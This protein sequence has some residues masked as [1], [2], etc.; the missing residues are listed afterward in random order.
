MLI[1]N[2]FLGILFISHAGRYWWSPLK[3]VAITVV[4]RL[5]LLPSIYHPFDKIIIIIRN[6][7]SAIMPL[8]GYRGFVKDFK[9]LNMFLVAVYHFFIT[10]CDV[11]VCCRAVLLYICAY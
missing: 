10:D 11:F 3:G 6:L 9:V 5:T 1:A 7:Y 8:S 2:T 4:D